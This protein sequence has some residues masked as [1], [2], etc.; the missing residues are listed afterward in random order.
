MFAA[1][2]ELSKIQQESEVLTSEVSD[3]AIDRKARKLMPAAVYKE[4]AE[5]Q[6]DVKTEK[7]RR[8][9]LREVMELKR[10]SSLRPLLE[11]LEKG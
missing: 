7:H 10:M 2:E 8:S 11:E 3:E 5:L 9:E 6:E 1:K 4:I